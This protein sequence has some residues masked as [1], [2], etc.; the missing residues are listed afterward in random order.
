M[1]GEQVHL[2]TGVTQSV[3]GRGSKAGNLVYRDMIDEEGRVIGVR[4]DSNDDAGFWLEIP[5]PK[6]SQTKET[7][8]KND[9]DGDEED[10]DDDE[11]EEEEK[12]N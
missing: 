6:T 9:E 1:I 11:K 5:Y 7:D 4:I 12:G 10:D 2:I 8:V 3:K